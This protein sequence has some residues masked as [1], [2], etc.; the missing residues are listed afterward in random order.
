MMSGLTSPQSK[1]SL[2]FGG[3]VDT[4]FA[5]GFGLESYLKRGLKRKEAELQ[6]RITTIETEL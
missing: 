3:G 5:S 1:T 6:S 4:A 2:L